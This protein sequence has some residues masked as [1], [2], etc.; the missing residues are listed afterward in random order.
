MRERSST[1]SLAR[2]TLALLAALTNPSR[3]EQDFNATTTALHAAV[4]KAYCW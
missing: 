4:D 1:P 3:A 2:P